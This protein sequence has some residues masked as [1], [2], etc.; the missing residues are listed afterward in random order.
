MMKSGVFATALLVA[1]AAHAQLE[2][3]MEDAI[4]RETNNLVIAAITRD[5]AAVERLL[6]SGTDV[7]Q[8]LQ[9]RTAFEV[10]VGNGDVEIVQALLAAG[11]DVNMRCC[12]ANALFHAARTRD[13]EMVKVLMDANID[14]DRQG[15]ITGDTALI[16]GI[17]HKSRRDPV[18]MEIARLVLEA[19]A[20]VNIENRIGV[21]ALLLAVQTDDS[22]SLAMVEALLARGADVDHRRCHSIPDDSPARNRV[23]YVRAVGGT[24]LGLA[25]MLGNTAAVEALI[26]AGAD[27]NLPHCDGRTPLELAMENGHD[28]MSY[29]LRSAISSQ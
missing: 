10:A 15:G 5:L 8:R 23:P 4:A 24:A 6:E 18:P 19:G 3:P 27:V 26:A 22:E 7:N 14:L 17:R 21:T 1:Y 28:E 12:G 13:L 9:N 16:L 20:D 11:A 2:N 29:I 25:S